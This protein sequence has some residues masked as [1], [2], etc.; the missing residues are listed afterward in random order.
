MKTII[1][2][3][4]HHLPNSEVLEFLDT[5]PEK[6]L[7]ILEIKERQQKH[8]PNEITQKKGEGPLIIFLR[9]FNQPLV[10]ILLA[11]SG[12]TAFLKEWADM[13]VILGVVLVNAIIGFIQEA[14]AI[15]AIDA[16]SKSMESESTVLRA[17]GKKQVSAREL[18]PGDIV[19]LQSGDRVPADLRLI[20]CR[21][22]QIDESA[23]TGES[24]PVEKGTDQLVKDTVLAERTNMVY[25][26]TLVTY[27]TGAGVVAAIGD[28]TEIGQI[29]EMI[30]SAEVLETPLSK[31]IARLSH[32]LLWGILG[33]AGATVIYGF[34]RG[35]PLNE[36]FL[37]A[38]AL[39]VGAIPEGLPAVITIT[40]AIGVARMAERHAIIRKL[41]AVETLGSTTVI[42]SDKT[43]TLT[44]NEMT[45]KEV[46]TDGKVFTVSGVGYAPEGEFK[47][48]IESNISL[49]ETLKAGLLCNDSRLISTDEGWRV[50]GDPT[51]GAL[52]T[53]AQKAGLA[54]EK[55]ELGLPLIDTIPFESQYQ[56]MATLHDKGENAPKL[57]YLKG[58]AES[59]LP[60]CQD[61]C[62]I[63]GEKVNLDIEF[64]HKSVD[65][66]AAKGLRVLAFACLEVP[67]DTKS[68]NHES[69]SKGLTF[70]GLQAMIDPPRPEAIQ[71]VLACQS[72][73]VQVK[74]ITGDH[75]GTAT[76]IAR[77]LGLKGAEGE[78]GKPVSGKDLENMSDEEL[79][80]S[81]DDIS[82]YARVAPAQKLRLVEALQAKGHVAAMTGDGV[83][84]APA[85]RQAN[86]GVAMGIT[87]TE[88]AKETADMVLTDDNFATIEAAAEEGRGV[89]DNLIKFIT[90]TLPTNLCE[91]LVILIAVFTGLA[92]PILPLQILWINMTT[93]VFLGASL[94]FEKKEPG[95]MQRPPRPPQ[96][97]ILTKPLIFRIMWVGL[98]LV[99]GAFA[100]YELTIIDGKSIEEAR[101]AAVNLIVFGELFYLLSCRSLKHSMF[102]VGVFSNIWLIIGV[103]AMVFLQLFFTY[104]K[105]MN[106]IFETRPISLK[107]WIV[108]IVAGIVVYSLSELDKLRLN[109]GSKK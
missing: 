11:A 59:I 1:T 26:S 40:L 64:I 65:I 24:V 53:S 36:M 56:Y 49:M 85:M 83:N 93:A 57:I 84:D 10:Y 37:A 44:Q 29:N 98:L 67:A 60:R 43:G 80:D 89:F 14:K 88:V 41:P 18:V 27:G 63:N 50:E 15:K 31:K 104:T 51:E 78:A 58:S 107:D 102:K 33:M 70:L 62:S 73:G 3:H 19:T 105:I 106:Q 9:Q 86:I 7:D 81:V 8:G 77:E 92:L 28:D 5:D 32:I 2:E 97:P 71:S 61:T 55:I 38:V 91:G 109:R 72:A 48:D 82:V 75:V 12:G 17:G 42:C 52:I 46:L 94:A 30:A 76:A 68:I 6:G 90:W 16:L 34:F 69:V 103:S 95:I 100:V 79:I 45:V 13:S 99:F 39:A 54:R 74:M 21:E 35:S 47:P 4:W 87:G 22:L 20:K 66:M 23:L 25:S 101:T 108:I 96:M